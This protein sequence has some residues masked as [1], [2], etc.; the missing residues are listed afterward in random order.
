M[1]FSG[2]TQDVIVFWM[3]E[4]MRWFSRKEQGMTG[5]EAQCTVPG[6]NVVSGMVVQVV[7]CDGDEYHAVEGCQS[8]N[9]RS[10]WRHLF[11]E[12]SSSGNER[13][14]LLEC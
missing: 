2:Q 7:A 10:W 6:G 3:L 13:L 4:P 14:H 11:N 12:S 8:A 1:L 5:T 9:S